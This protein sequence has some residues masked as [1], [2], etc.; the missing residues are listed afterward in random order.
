MTLFRIIASLISLVGLGVGF[1][2]I[3]LQLNAIKRDLEVLK[4]R[5]ER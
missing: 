1:V 5:S 4:Q 3:I 2:V